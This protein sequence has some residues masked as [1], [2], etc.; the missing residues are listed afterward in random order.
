MTMAPSL[1]LREDRASRW[2]LLVSL[3]LN[4][5][6]VGA[7][8]AWAAR[9]Y[10]APPA[11][12]TP[13]FDRSV[14]ARIERLAATL[15]PADGDIL[16]ASYRANATAVAG[17]RDLYRRAQDETR[18]I[19]RSEPFDAEAMRAA[20]G[21]TRVARQGFDQLLQDVIA[22]AAARM[23]PAGRNKLADWPPTQRGSATNR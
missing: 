16:R 3:G 23:T 20:M 14:A 4:L 8:G 13:W 22:A 18:G 7:G 19:L 15:P 12:T 10:F 17:A 1:S 11:Q 2:I 21:R 5:F 9:H 6:L